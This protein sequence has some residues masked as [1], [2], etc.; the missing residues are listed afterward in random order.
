MNTPTNADDDD[1]ILPP[2][3]RAALDKFRNSLQICASDDQKFEVCIRYRDDLLS[4]YTKLGFLAARMVGIMKSECNKFR[5][6]S[7][8][9][10]KKSGLSDAE[11]WEKFV[12]VAREGS[13]KLDKCLPPLRTVKG[14]WGKEIAQHYRWAEMGETYCKALSSAAL[15][16]EDLDEFL[17]KVGQLLKRRLQMSK[18]RK[19]RQAINPI[20]L[21]ELENVRLWNVYGSYIKRKDGANVK[22]PYQ[23]LTLEDV[24]EGFGLDKFG[25]IVHKEFAEAENLTPPI[26]EDQQTMPAAA[27]NNSL[28]LPLQTPQNGTDS[29]PIESEANASNLSALGTAMSA[30]SSSQVEQDGSTS[31]RSKDTSIDSSENGNDEVFPRNDSVVENSISDDEY[32]TARSQS[33]SCEAA[34]DNAMGGADDDTTMSTRSNSR[35]ESTSHRSET[36]EDESSENSDDNSDETGDDAPNVT[37]GGDDSGIDIDTDEGI[38]TNPVTP[39]L[40]VSDRLRVVS[41]TGLRERS[42]RQRHP[43]LKISTQV[44]PR[45]LSTRPSKTATQSNK[46]VD[47]KSRNKCGCNTEALETLET[48]RRTLECSYIDGCT[49]S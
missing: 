33:N 23:R 4:D 45:P 46:S 7:R 19:L 28:S 18:R 43:K 3:E 37:E 31:H 21:V 16:I 36:V 13:Q 24:P 20:D 17:I 29:S 10:W 15:K 6:K 9:G 27:P 30:R 32:A 12:G 44:R 39:R 47:R 26:P 25:L 48:L 38:T 35:D 42:S 1:I 11:D 34:E 8:V 2:Q 14:T 41:E 49:L 22:L 40:R 5:T